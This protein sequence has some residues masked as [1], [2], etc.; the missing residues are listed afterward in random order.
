MSVDLR[1]FSMF[2][3]FPGLAGN[4]PV[5]E[6]AGNLTNAGQDLGIKAP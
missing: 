2:A 4:V 6:H 3:I 1:P 5:P